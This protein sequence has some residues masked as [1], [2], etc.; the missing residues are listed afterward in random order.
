DVQRARPV[1][2]HLLD[3]CPHL[4]PGE[5]AVTGS[6]PRDRNARNALAVGLGSHALQGGLDGLVAGPGPPDSFL[7]TQVEHPRPV[8][9]PEPGI[10]EV[11][12]AGLGLAL[13]AV[14][15]VHLWVA[16]AEARGDAGPHRALAVAAVG[17]GPGFVAV[18]E[19]V[20]GDELD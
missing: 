8:G 6:D 14:L 7:R 18:G 10:A 13:A 11:E 5:A 4:L 12:L 9:L 15:R 17:Q 19:Q 1:P 2:E 20:T 16:V 3:H